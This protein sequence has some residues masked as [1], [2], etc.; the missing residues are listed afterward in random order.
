[1]IAQRPY[2]QAQHHMES[3]N[4]TPEEITR[5][6]NQLKWLLISLRISGVTDLP[7]RSVQS[8]P[9]VA[10]CP[11]EP[12]HQLD[13]PEALAGIRGEIG[14][15]KRCRL[16]A[17]RTHI[18]FGEGAPRARLVFVGEG[19]GF[20][21][22]QQGRPF[23]GRAGKLLDKMIE[24]LGLQ[25]EEVY[26]CNVVKCRP[27]NNRT[28]NPDE[29]D[30]CSRFLTQQLAAISPQTICAL[31]SCAAQTLL[32]ATTSVSRLRGRIHRWRGIPVICTFHPAYLLRN[33]SQKASSWQ[34]LR[35]VDRVLHEQERG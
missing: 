16:H 27:P 9:A 14:D 1:M 20:E 21:E 17:E 33:P 19:P 15:C 7:T 12:A 31:G 34:D 4:F 26:I 24:S 23:V 28:P 22:D 3:F 35:E 8:R 25:R 11:K 2:W 18:V 30:L 32:G 13:P 5:T 29:I 10:P 6:L